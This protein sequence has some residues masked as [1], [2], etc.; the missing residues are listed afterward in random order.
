MKKCIKQFSIDKRNKIC[1]HVGAI[2][3]VCIQT[4]VRSLFHSVRHKMTRALC[5]MT[6]TLNFKF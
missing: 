4:I 3:F 2:V 1:A 6:H 5:H